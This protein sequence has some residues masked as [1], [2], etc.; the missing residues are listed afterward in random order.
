[1][2]Q[3]LGW[4]VPQDV[5]GD[6]EYRWW[7]VSG[8]RVLVLLVLS[9]AP[10][11]YRGHFYRGRMIPCL[12]EGCKVCAEKVGAQ[13][14]FVVAAADVGTHRSGLLE[15]GNT[16]ALELRD[17]AVRHDGL[18]GLVVEISKHSFSRQSRMELKYVDREEPPWWREI[19]VPDIE[20]AL[21]LTWQKSGYDMPEIKPKITPASP[22]VRFVPPSRRERVS[23]P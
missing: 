6:L 4:D 18:K 23:S 1:M 12:G 22:G 9:E 13:L 14:R 3:G 20:L 21:W 19:D 17:L 8:N 15:V 10:H 5:R 16:V 11:W 7:R 2:P